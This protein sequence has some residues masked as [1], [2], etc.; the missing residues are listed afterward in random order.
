MIK[1]NIEKHPFW[2]FLLIELKEK[3]FNTLFNK[4]FNSFMILIYLFIIYNNPLKTLYLFHKNIPVLIILLLFYIVMFSGLVDFIYFTY[5]EVKKRIKKH[6]NQLNTEFNHGNN[7]LL[8]YYLENKA[9]INYG[10]DQEFSDN[11]LRHID[12]LNLQDINGNTLLHLMITDNHKCPYISELL[13]LGANPY[14]KN[15]KNISAIDLMPEERKILF[16]KNDEKQVANILNSNEVDK[17]I[18]K[19]RRL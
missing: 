14:I 16:I 10:F 9:L 11:L 8:W 12:K 6:K 17:T 2:Y 19:E 7:F 4:I 3:C 18:K 15:N 13:L 5:S 1:I